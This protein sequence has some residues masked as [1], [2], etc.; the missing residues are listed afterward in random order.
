MLTDIS[1]RNFAIIESTTL[2]FYRGESV[3]T[4]E[5][6]SG[7]SLFVDALSFLAGSKLDRRAS[8]F[9]DEDTLVEAVFSIPKNTESLQQVLDKYGLSIED[10]QIIISRSYDQ[11]TTKTRVNSRIVS[12]SVL[13]ELMAE[14]IN[15]HSQNSQSLLS[16]KNNYI[17]FLDQFVGEELNSLKSALLHVITDL[18]AIRKEKEKFD[19]SPEELE[20]QLDLLDY[21]IK[22]I[23]KANLID[24]DEDALNE[25]YKQLTS[26][27][28]RIEAIN[29]IIAS[30]AGEYSVRS[31]IS[32]IA[33]EL[34]SLT[35]RDEGLKDINDSSWQLEADSENLEHMLESYRDRIVIDP[36]RIEEIDEIFSVLQR[37]KRKYGD[38]IEEILHYQDQCQLELEELSA[39]DE[40]RD[41]LDQKENLLRKEAQN[42]AGQI[43]EKRREGG[44]R[45]EE[46]I[47]DELKQMA[48]QK[49]D[50]KVQVLSDQP[51]ATNGQDD[52]DFLI[53][54]N[55]GQPMHSVSEVAS[56][57]EMSRFML[58]F[59]I[60]IA[61][62]QEIPTLVFDEIDTGISGRTA[63]VVGEKLQ[64]LGNK[65]QLIVISHLP[66]IAALANNHYLIEK[67]V[68]DGETYSV[69]SLL[70]RDER[71]E[72]QSRLIGGTNITNLTRN[73][74]EEMLEQAS[75]L[76]KERDS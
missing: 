70:D 7:K 47:K 64:R 38:S 15:I 4:G 45:L 43:S 33:R 8:R 51:I 9:E 48:I 73:S 34:D 44:K 23:D 1:I 46:R 11:K 58:A 56:G 50:F 53:S 14:L 13:R 74:A 71:I 55:V 19:L 57:G 67:K 5:T 29:R 10:G 61:E 12:Q 63:Q 22:E 25:E 27:K 60:V 16:N 42:I 26:S 6:G 75:L 37:L 31:A 59:N 52:V 69:M 65:H 66:Q 2:S 3:V 17:K 76:Q 35:R 41:Y 28:D 20:R 68:R 62:V 36:I 21:Q 39:I 32:S 54:T 72:E 40:R 24:I 30:F 49:I 18:R